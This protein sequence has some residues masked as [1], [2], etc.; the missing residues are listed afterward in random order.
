MITEVFMKSEGL[1]VNFILLLLIIPFF[2]L[3]VKAAPN[4]DTTISP[5]VNRLTKTQEQKGK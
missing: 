1:I 5:I 2:S 4:A 3:I